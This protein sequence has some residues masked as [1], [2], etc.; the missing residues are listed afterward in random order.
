MLR[1]RAP[2]LLSSLVALAC[3]SEPDRVR[4]AP[5]PSEA[6]GTAPS[7]PAAPAAVA[8]TPPQESRLERILKIE[9]F[10]D[11]LAALKP[12]MKDDYNSVSDGSTMLMIWA[13]KNPIAF[14]R[15][16]QNVVKD[17]WASMLSAQTSASRIKKDPVGERG[18]RICAWGHVVS[19]HYQRTDVGN[20]N[21]GQLLTSVGDVFDYVAIE[22]DPAFEKEIVERTRVK[23]CG[24]FTELN[25]YPNSAGGTSHGLRVIG[26]FFSREE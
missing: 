18:K 5:A 8:T 2:L 15:N 21:S 23:L 26:H 20:I 25:D 1:K 4:P 22:A 3:S 24:V 13:A 6:T 19:I 9:S 12:L 10:E 16:F 17:R 14:R 11:A 7:Q